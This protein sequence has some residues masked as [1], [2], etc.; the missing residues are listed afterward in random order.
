MRKI[1]R[2]GMIV[3][4]M[5]VASACGGGGTGVEV[6]GA[7]ART[8]PAAADAGAVYMQMTSSEDDRLVGVSVDPSIAAAAQVHETV[9]AEP[10]GDE[11]EGMGAMM[12]QEVGA[13]DLS[14]GETVALQPG[15]LHIMLLGLRSP[16]EDGRMFD[17]TLTFKIAG[18][19]T[20]EVVVGDSAP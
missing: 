8:S 16:L 19:Q 13:I 4:L 11:G 6:E 3:A 5:V 14:A 12:M 1:E 9:M 17:V 18:E 10:M 15:G 2:G 7:W 20:Y